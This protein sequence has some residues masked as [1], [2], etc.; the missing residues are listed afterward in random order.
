M[1]GSHVIT[2]KTERDLLMGWCRFVNEVD[3]DIITGYNIQ[4]F[5]I[6]YLLNRAAC[7]SIDLKP[8]PYLG[9]IPS[10]KTTMR[11]S[12]FESKAYGKRVNKLISIDGRVQF[13]LLRVSIL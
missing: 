8:F 11:D 7:S 6:P 13:D 5:D 3:P 2:N 1:V 12:T 10:N 4:N 9:R